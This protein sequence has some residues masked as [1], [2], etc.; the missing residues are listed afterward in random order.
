MKSLRSRSNPWPYAAVFYLLAFQNP[1]TVYLW[2]G[3]SYLDELFALGG[4]AVFLLRYCLCGQ[5]RIRRDTVLLL[6]MLAGFVLC[7]VAGNLRF[8]YQPMKAV[9]KDIYTN[10]KFFLSVLAGYYLFRYADPGKK[11][12]LRHCH[13]G[14]LALSVL[15]AADIVFGIFPT[16]GIRYGVAVRS[17]I[18]GHVTYLAGTCVFLLALVLMHYEARELP[19]L[20]L[21]LI[22]LISTLRG[23]ALAGAVVCAAIFRRVILQRKKPA[24][25][26]I[27][28]VGAVGILIAWE[29]I[30]YYYIDLAGES[31]RS[32][33]LLTSARI[34]GDCFPIGTGFGTYG[35]DVAASTYS[36]VYVRYGFLRHPELQPGSSFFSD[37][38][39]PIILGQ[40]GFLGTV[41]YL[42]ALALLFAKAQRI[43]TV[44]RNSYAAVLFLAAYLLI[45][46]TSEPTFCNTVSIPPAMLLGRVLAAVPDTERSVVYG[47]P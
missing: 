7:G 17:L 21:G 26:Q 11:S 46:S 14:I 42:A 24:L 12:M 31:A 25:A 38:F 3:F 15:L 19:F 9:L 1:L 45:S 18:F 34:V 32:Q 44:S 47:R 4:A 23:K 39:W 41:F 10:L 2:S 13:A 6:L 28:L 33:L 36:P 30:R 8:G 43:R 20:I 16:F 35:S 5:I 27:L 37:T 22:L 40:T 29:Q